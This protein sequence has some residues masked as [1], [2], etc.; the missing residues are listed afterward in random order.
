MP[1]PDFSRQG[2]APATSAPA[3]W[4]FA[5]TGAPSSSDRP[6][7]LVDGDA[8]A[9][10][11][12]GVEVARAQARA[13][14]GGP[15]DRQPGHGLAQAAAR[16]ELDRPRREAAGGEHDGVGRQ[17]PHPRR[18]AHP[19]AGHAP[20][21]DLDARP[22]PGPARARPPA[23]ASA[24][25]SGALQAHARDARRH[26]R[27]LGDR[28]AEQLLEVLPRLGGPLEPDHRRQ[29]DGLPRLDARAAAPRPGVAARP[30]RRARARAPGRPRPRARAAPDQPTSTGRASTAPP[31]RSARLRFSATSAGI[32]VLERAQARPRPGGRRR[33]GRRRRSLAGASAVGRAAPTAVGSSMLRPGRRRSGASGTSLAEPLQG[34]AQRLGREA[35]VG[36]VRVAR[37]RRR[38]GPPAARRRARARSP[39]TSMVPGDR[40]RPA[41]ALG[42][43][44]DRGAAL[45]EA[46]RGGEPGQA[47]ADDDDP[48]SYRPLRGARRAGAPRR[49]SPGRSSRRGPPGASGRRT[50]SARAPASGAA[51]TSAPARRRAR[52]R[53]PRG[54]GG[55]RPRG[56][57]SSR[58]GTGPSRA[59]AGAGSRRG[60][61]PG[62]ASAASTRARRGSSSHSQTSWSSAMSRSRAAR[63]VPEPVGAAVLGPRQH[64][65]RGAAGARRRRAARRWRRPRSRPSGGRWSACR[66]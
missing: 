15:A 54:R 17:R 23:A 19:H 43:D 64:L 21:G 24:A 4:R 44:R 10:E 45:R 48:A 25:V 12:L 57:C 33:A 56:T 58:P 36:V 27:H 38:A 26:R 7:A 32:E 28:R 6:H 40:C 62:R 11:R 39:S 8:A 18:L 51:G 55:S 34:L 14:G 2:S 31:G 29:Q 13:A 9:H 65:L 61:C 50:G 1:S 53:P 3:A 66:R 30:G 46:D 42:D 16:V 22:R 20:G 41:R 35:R 37:P 5:Q 59:A 60:S 63:R 52:R 47:R 49:G